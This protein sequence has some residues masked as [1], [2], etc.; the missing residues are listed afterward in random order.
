MATLEEEIRRRQAANALSLLDIPEAEMGAL[1]P[2]KKDVRVYGN[3]DDWQTVEP[4]VAPPPGHIDLGPP[5]IPLEIPTP[6]PE[7]PA[8]PTNVLTDPESGTPFVVDPYTKEK[9]PRAELATPA[10]KEAFTPSDV[11]LPQEMVT[12]TP[13]A[14]LVE[15]DPDYQYMTPEPRL[16]ANYVTSL[17]GDEEKKF[18]AWVKQ[19]N[20]PWQD[21]PNA[22]YD[23]RGY[24]KAQAEG[25]PNAVRSSKNLHFPDTYKTPYHKTFSNESQYASADAPHWEGDRLIDKD[26]NVVADETPKPAKNVPGF[27]E[28]SQNAILN[29]A[30]GVTPPVRRAELVPTPPKVERA[31]PVVTPVVT[32]DLAQGPPGQLVSRPDETQPVVPT[33]PTK[34][35]VAPVP[36]DWNTWKNADGT[37]AEGVAANPA[38]EITTNPNGT[39]YPSRTQAVGDKDPAAFI[40]HHT[41]G[42]KTVE[43]IL[44]T[45]KERGLGVEYIMD[46][47]GN[48]FK[49][50][51]AGA[52]NIKPGWGPKGTGLNN[53]NIVGMEIIADNDKDVNPAQKAAFARFIQARYPNT[54]LYGHGEV[55]PGHKEAD[56]GMS[57]KNAALALREGGGQAAEPTSSLDVLDTLSAG[58]LN[59]T[60]FGY[61]GDPNLDKA[62]ARGEGA[63]VANMIPGYDVALN[64]AAAR[65][66]GNPKPGEEFQYAGRTWRYGDKVP[67]QYSD[68]RFDIFDKNNT[69][70]SSGQLGKTPTKEG[71]PDEYWNNWQEVSP[72]ELQAAKGER[73]AKE[74]NQIDWLLDKYKNYS[75]LGT[76]YKEIDTN[77]N[78]DLELRTRVKDQIQQQ[79]TDQMIQYDP[80]LQKLAETDPEKAKML[81]WA[82]WHNSKGEVVNAGPTGLQADSLKDMWS[83][84]SAGHTA[85][86]NVLR[87]PI[88]NEQQVV[89][90]FFKYAGA[91]SEQKKQDILNKIHD[92]NLSKGQQYDLINKMLPQD[93]GVMNV[94]YAT[95]VTQALD[96][97][98]NPGWMQKETDRRAKDIHDAA[99]KAAGD[100]RMR[101]T[102]TGSFNDTVAMLTQLGEA[103]AILPG[104]V[105]TL[106]VVSDQVHA[107]YKAEHPDWTEEQVNKA[108][109]W[110]TLINSLGMEAGSKVFATVFSPLLEKIGNPVARRLANAFSAAL[111]GGTTAAGASAITGGSAKEIIKQGIL[112][113]TL[114]FGHGIM[115]LPPGPE[116]REPAPIEAPLRTAPQLEHVPVTEP[117]FD[118]LPPEENPSGQ[119]PLKQG[120][121]WEHVSPE[122]TL[123]DGFRG[124]VV[125][126][127]TDTNG[128][129][130]EVNARNE[131]TARRGEQPL[132]GDRTGTGAARGEELETPPILGRTKKAGET[133]APTGYGAG[134]IAG[135][136]SDAF[137]P[138]RRAATSEDE[139]LAQIK[140]FH[141]EQKKVITAM[142]WEHEPG[143]APF[144]HVRPD[145]HTIYV[146]GSP[147]AYFNYAKEHGI[148]NP[149]A[150]VEF[151]RKGMDEEITHA[152]DYHSLRDE[153][154]AE[155]AAGRM[156]D[157]LE[158]HR[159]S[160]KQA[161]AAAREIFQAHDTAVATGNHK[162]AKI[163]RNAVEHGEELYPQWRGADF[164]GIRKQLASTKPQEIA[165]ARASLFATRFEIA[166]QMDQAARR[167]EVSE[168]ELPLW[169]KMA[170]SLSLTIARLINSFKRAHD[171]ALRGE[172]GP[173]MQKH[174]QGLVNKRRAMEAI[175]HGEKPPA[176][177]AGAFDRP[178][179]VP[180]K[181]EMAR[182]RSATRDPTWWEKQKTAFSS[183][184]KGGESFGLDHPTTQ[185]IARALRRIPSHRQNI[186]QYAGIPELQR[187]LADIK[188]GVVRG[189]LGLGEHAKI[190]KEFSDWF[191][192]RDRKQPPPVLSPKAD[193]LVKATVNTLDKLGSIAQRMGIK[194]TDDK[195]NVHPF[196][197]IK[198][199]FPRIISKDTENIFENRNG[200]RAADFQRLL[201]DAIHKGMVKT[202]D[203]FIQKFE[204]STMPE[205][206]SNAFFANAEL[207]RQMHLPLEMHDWSPTGI[208]R[209]VSRMT[210]R[211]AEIKGVGQ[212][213]NASTHDLF[214]L[215]EADI[216][217]DRTLSRSE[218]KIM[219]TRVNQIRQAIYRKEFVDSL[220]GPM[221]RTK[222][223]VSTSALGNWF[224]SANNT[225]GGAVSNIGF[226]GPV[227]AAKAY[228]KVLYNSILKKASLV[229]ETEDRGI[230]GHNLH[231]M[232]T[233]FE[234]VLSPAWATKG[235]S[236]YN[237]FMM[238]WGGQNETEALNRTVA[239]QQGKY[240]L[241][242]FQKWGAPGAQTGFFGARARH[243][244][245]FFKRRGLSDIELQRLYREGG[246]PNKPIGEEFIRQYVMDTHGNY[247]PGQ[248]ASHLFDTPWGKVLLMFQKFTANQSRMNTREYMAP[249]ARAAKGL[250]KNTPEAYGDFG[251][252]FLRNMG[253]FGFLVPAGGMAISGAIN[254]MRDRKDPSPSAIQIGKEFAKGNT[255]HGVYELF[256]KVWQAYQLA[257]MTGPMG[258][259]AGLGMAALG[260][261]HDKLKNPLNPPMY[262]IMIQPVVEYLQGVIQEGGNVA[263]PT[264]L[265][266]LRENISAVRVGSNIV[267]GVENRLGVDDPA[268]H[269]GRENQL[270]NDSI[271]LSSR[272]RMYEDEHP[273]LKKQN[274]PP[275]VRN[276]FSPYRDDLMA[277]LRYGDA[278]LAVHA[279]NTYL[280]KFP[281]AEAAKRL[282]AIQASVSSSTPI[283][284]GG[285]YSFEHQLEFLR[286]AKDT[287]APEDAR[288]LFNIA[289]TYARTAMATNFLASPSMAA[290][291]QLNFDRISPPPKA[292][293]PSQNLA[294]ATAG[295]QLL[296]EMKKREMILKQQKH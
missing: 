225:I 158:F 240:L 202:K 257:G 108:A 167:G 62:S 254:L 251:Y 8:G 58:G 243:M 52:Q 148:K 284:P 11:T 210:D 143:P 199:Y 247:S 44:S 250:V 138:P 21:V 186:I 255:G 156:P 77:T 157:T 145:G 124:K 39:P 106:A 114:S 46:R 122:Q 92:P 179:D 128:N 171:A 241:E 294:A 99:V 47:D 152:L 262:S 141:E 111:G 159:W 125:S 162:L 233:D 154:D 98:G 134:D 142:G 195:G 189:V 102:F 75:N 192:A 253:H 214:D 64:A 285:Q 193:R 208:M 37:P 174:M 165:N 231:D 53:S 72:S 270:R 236:G 293:T 118:V 258:N 126:D 90:R 110:D 279:V 144:V 42:G 282:K 147:E 7:S 228:G 18:Q 54:P 223:F 286:W 103:N 139:A 246:D 1:Q 76:V 204:R 80:D 217:A 105:G 119:P 201:A 184:F 203:E 88:L 4:D 12:R 287:Q 45:L 207:S 30:A 91:D 132:L 3:W 272:L 129:V 200:S 256:Q 27:V 222:N 93:T 249:M 239:M 146:G 31:Q 191:Q 153:Y 135:A 209:Y 87:N 25:D 296:L 120:R 224:T 196:T 211:L 245:E 56:E 73:T 218:K 182:P 263:D 71:Q 67:E 9:I 14:T 248:T 35:G 295:R 269:L 49:T 226:G 278:G 117:H 260:F 194:V 190:S 229:K 19:N 280:A 96:H 100:P 57:A 291:A 65:L 61:R 188:G 177:T 95:E 235:Q 16:P 6:T 17:S 10:E 140:V 237:R 133:I 107:K 221:Q 232:S 277:G 275:Q 51:E 33:A 89:N 15:P 180:P 23:M 24:W 169:K 66:V 60:H 206:T 168:T 149:A 288:Q 94:P 268:L 22:D 172:L 234:K 78:I 28:G 175:A 197:M 271:F 151:A 181:V 161:I 123:D 160:S 113:S 79:M 266:N 26:G 173:L 101:D 69:I 244:E 276:D 164:N 34:P 292:L 213:I 163:I 185:K 227:S 70:F 109:V 81:A 68:A 187:A 166:R 38:Q 178:G 40:V 261:T 43:G 83:K 115:H 183:V 86:T 150:M 242:K 104:G 116:P 259:Y 41:S 219:A 137:G 281:P 238:K 121:V 264:L 48:I 29:P 97:L 13:R 32:G 216:A 265:K 155:K 205:T 127:H 289:Q 136:R 85:L 267:G 50:G 230:M 55:N 63:Y 170:K 220:A 84:V 82:K 273:E 176:D 112:G 212:K 130:S 74:K 198:N 59:A 215:T 2:S 20:I 290:M 274:P 283:R 36:G 252:Q 131:Q 5:K